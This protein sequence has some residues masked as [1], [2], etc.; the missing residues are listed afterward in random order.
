MSCEILK[1]VGIIQEQVAATA[2]S[3]T[4]AMSPLSDGGVKITPE[5]V[6]EILVKLRQSISTMVELE[7]A[8]EMGHSVR[9]YNTLISEKLGCAM[10]K[11]VP[12]GVGQG[13]LASNPHFKKSIYTLGD[14]VAHLD[15]KIAETYSEG[16][17]AEGMRG[18]RQTLSAIA[19][20]LRFFDELKV[21]SEAVETLRDSFDSVKVIED[22]LCDFER[23]FDEAFIVRKDP[24]NVGIA[25]G[26]ALGA[27]V[28]AEEVDGDMEFFDD[29][30][31]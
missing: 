18:I 16:T 30:A 6:D 9:L 19:S 14:L 24:L 13:E 8:L 20:E 11:L 2:F 15:D 4:Q 23:F 28:L 10:C 21:L 25:L 26:S 5:E 3:I 27:V 31:I 12:K 17:H 22:W 7:D 1:R 29:P